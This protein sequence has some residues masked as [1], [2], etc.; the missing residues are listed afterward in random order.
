MKAGVAVQVFS[1]GN[2]DVL[3]VTGLEPAEPVTQRPDSGTL[4]TPVEVAAWFGEAVAAGI[5]FDALKTAAGALIRRGWSRRVKQRSADQVTETVKRYLDTNGYTGTVFSDI[6][7]IDGKG[8]SF[9]GLVDDGTFK[10]L[11]DEHGNV[12]HVRV[13]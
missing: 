7:K 5:T 9:A 3:L 4:F 8:W 2:G 11:T 6:R 13:R 12:I 10:G 1:L